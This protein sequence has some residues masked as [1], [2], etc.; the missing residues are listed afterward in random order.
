[1]IKKFPTADNLTVLK[2]TANYQVV[3]DGE[4]D[5]FAVVNA[6]PNYFLLNK[7]TNKIET[8]SN[9]SYDV[10]FLIDKMQEYDDLGFMD[11]AKMPKLKPDTEIH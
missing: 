4:C 3:M 6:I 11:I 7:K 1:M 8:V 10:F 2:E 5:M 9:S